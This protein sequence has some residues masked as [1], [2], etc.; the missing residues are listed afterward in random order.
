M[1]SIRSRGRD[2]TVGSLTPLPVEA[3]S[4]QATI[5]HTDNTQQTTQSPNFVAQPENDI[6]ISNNDF[7]WKS[8][9]ALTWSYQDVCSWVNTIFIKDQVFYG[10]LFEKNH[11]D[12]RC[13]A[14]LSLSDMKEIGIDSLGHRITIKETYRSIYANHYQ[15]ECD[16]GRNQDLSEIMN[17]FNQLQS[18]FVQFRNEILTRSVEDSNISQLHTVVAQYAD[19]NIASASDEK[20]QKLESRRP[21][22]DKSR[23]LAPPPKAQANGDEASKSCL[24]NE[25]SQILKSGRTSLKEQE[26]TTAHQTQAAGNPVDSNPTAASQSADLQRMTAP[27]NP[28][29]KVPAPKPQPRAKPG[30]AAPKAVPPLAGAPASALPPAAVPQGLS[31]AAAPA[32]AAEAGPALDIPQPDGVV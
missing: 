29:K 28:Q 22:R 30:H 7:A 23:D 6:S 26:V 5:N 17:A 25:G 21:A 16:N 1:R 19:V 15:N 11:I 31:E 13:L 4:R 10:S 2:R 14:A 20:R 3:I 32:P 27:G 12:G 24:P 18:S 8:K 9:A